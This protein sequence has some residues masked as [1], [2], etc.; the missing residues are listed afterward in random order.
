ME[1]GCISISW[2]EKLE[3]LITVNWCSIS[4]LIRENANYKTGSLQVNSSHSRREKRRG[5]ERGKGGR[6]GGGKEA[7]H[8]LAKDG[9]TASAGSPEPRATGPPPGPQAPSPF[10]GARSSESIIRPWWAGLSQG[11]APSAVPVHRQPETDQPCYINN[12]LTPGCVNWSFTISLGDSL[13][14]QQDKSF[15][16]WLFYWL[17]GPV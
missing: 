2:K 11:G 12:I 17:P 16:L 15:L 4:F 14:N 7:W 5:R 13:C 3:W 10:Y 8:R 9:S 1:R 6:D